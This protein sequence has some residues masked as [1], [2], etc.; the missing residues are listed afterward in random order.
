MITGGTVAITEL[1]IAIVII[2]LIR[3]VFV[4]LVEIWQRIADVLD[5]DLG[6]HAAK[7]ERVNV[8]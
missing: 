7:L 4:F 1:N 2:I 6:R 3:A 8:D 5:L